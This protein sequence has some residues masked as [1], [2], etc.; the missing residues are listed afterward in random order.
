MATTV[1]RNSLLL[2]SLECDKL[3]TAMLNKFFCKPSATYSTSALISLPP[4][5][6]S[7]LVNRHLSD[8]LI[9]AFHQHSSLVNLT[10][11]GSH[12]ETP[13]NHDVSGSSNS[14]LNGK[15]GQPTKR[16]KPKQA[17]VFVSNLLLSH[18]TFV[19]R[20][21]LVS[22][23]TSSLGKSQ[24]AQII[25]RFRPTPALI[26]HASSH[27][28][29]RSPDAAGVQEFKKELK[30]FLS[31]VLKI[32]E[33]IHSRIAIYNPFLLT[34]ENVSMTSSLLVPP[35]IDQCHTR[36]SAWPPHNNSVIDPATHKKPSYLLFS[37]N[38]S[39]SSILHFNNAT[40]ILD[41]ARRQASRNKK[42][43]SLPRQA[44]SLP[45]SLKP[46]MTTK[47]AGI[48]A[49]TTITERLCLQQL[50]TPSLLSHSLN[51]GSSLA[52]H[53][54][55]I[56]PDQQTKSSNRVL[57]NELRS[58]QQP[59]PTHPKQL[60][61]SQNLHLSSPQLIEDPI[62]LPATGNTSAGDPSFLDPSILL[63]GKAVHTNNNAPRSSPFP[64][65]TS[66]PPHQLPPFYQ[67]QQDAAISPITVPSNINPHMMAEAVASA[68][69]AMGLKGSHHQ[70]QKHHGQTSN[71]RS[72]SPLYPQSEHTGA[73][74]FSR[75]AVNLSPHF[76][77]PHYPP[78]TA[79]P[80]AA[81]YPLPLP[82][83]AAAVVT[84]NTALPQL[85]HQHG[86]HRQRTAGPYPTAP[87]V[88]IK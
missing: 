71:T 13:G 88:D 45:S 20:C 73:V 25:H 83:P 82:L 44:V 74:P 33:I 79:P 36:P 11:G 7:N 10:N 14:T 28:L 43:F 27:N 69:A 86:D 76:N 48:E 3:Y 50:L 34:C 81:Y 85:R 68:I 47:R 38:A 12:E 62:N 42:P 29:F 65:Q 61:K 8:R 78:P 22:V 63:T 1:D 52:P 17:P 4:D 18:G 26:D 2:R 87:A 16:S 15:E 46:E 80:T 75:P 5:M 58:H 54:N 56:Q 21:D 57:S 37:H 9:Q 59:T 23:S 55:N 31:S 84:A 77:T 24:L 60:P 35:S 40:E 67:M 64:L 53:L 6:E 49:A 72:S 41:E 51:N 19:Q 39:S 32:E 70:P 66:Q 30:A